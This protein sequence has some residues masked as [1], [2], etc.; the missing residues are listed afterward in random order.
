MNKKYLKILRTIS[1]SDLPLI[2]L[3]K[4]LAHITSLINGEIT[5]INQSQKK[6]AIKLIKHIK[7]ENEML[8]E[9]IEAYQ[10]YST[11]K[12]TAKIKGDIAE[13]GV[14]QGGSA[15]LICQTKGNKNLHLFDT[16]KGLPS[17]SAKDNS[18]QFH[19]SQFTANLKTVKNY[20][21]KYD[22]VHFYP[23]IFPLSAK[24]G[25]NIKFSFVHLDLDIFK[26]TRDALHFFYPRMTPGGII[27]SHDYQ[28]APGV[29]K[30]FDN[31]FQNKPEAI[32]KL[33]N[34]QCLIV[35]L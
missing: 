32:V 3:K 30:A 6:K 16:F 14:Y 20:L 9:N 31:F 19:Q 27:I 25:K 28:N 11:V 21:K 5:Y 1:L 29:R 10:I 7:T 12:A 18:N 17:I 13:A 34:S 35:K 24:I 4:N 8:L 2:F 33:N 22:N 15:K 26:S 23:G